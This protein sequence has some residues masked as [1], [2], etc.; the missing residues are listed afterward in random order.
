MDDGVDVVGRRGGRGGGGVR[1][2]GRLV[3][4]DQSRAPQDVG[5]RTTGGMKADQSTAKLVVAGQGRSVAIELTA[6]GASSV[7]ADTH[8]NNTAR[9]LQ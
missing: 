3:E 5:T 2:G 6:E 8:S 9:R 1:E 4:S 7:M